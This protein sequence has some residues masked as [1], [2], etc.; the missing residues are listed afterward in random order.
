M[1]F[2]ARNVFGTFEKR[3]PGQAVWFVYVIARSRGQ[4]RVNL[5]SKF[6]KIRD[7]G[8]LENFENTSEINP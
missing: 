7:E 6:H 1:A 8:N 2:R 3:A 5:S 4:W